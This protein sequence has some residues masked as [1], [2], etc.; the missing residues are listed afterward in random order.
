M[1]RGIDKTALYKPKQKGKNTKANPIRVD[2]LVTRLMDG[3]I[4]EISEAMKI[5][6]AAAVRMLIWF[7]MRFAPSADLAGMTNKRSFD[8]D[9]Q[10]T[11]RLD[12]RITQEMLGEIERLTE[13]EN[14]KKSRVI[15]RYLEW[16]LANIGSFTI[17]DWL[18]K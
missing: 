10:A 13:L 11:Q 17:G 4:S 7:A 16:A 14:V 15:K 18:S 12:T 9:T 2:V 1:N 6:K 3:Q 5:E 8:T